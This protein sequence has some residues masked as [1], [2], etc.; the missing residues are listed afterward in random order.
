[1]N[2]PIFDFLEE[3]MDAK[4]ILELAAWAWETDAP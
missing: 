2:N 3:G 1:M 4:W